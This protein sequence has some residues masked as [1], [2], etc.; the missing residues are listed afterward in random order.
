LK[1]AV[2]RRLAGGWGEA[3]EQGAQ[4]QNES[5]HRH[6]QGCPALAN[7]Q[8]THVAP[9]GEWPGQLIA[10]AEQAVNR[11]GEKV[12]TLPHEQTG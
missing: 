9:A 12:T 8:T 5:Q 7:R 6:A 3:Q 10:H 11:C 1:L 2:S 4:K